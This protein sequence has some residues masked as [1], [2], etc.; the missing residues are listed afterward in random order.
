[1]AGAWNG[2]TTDGG[3]ASGHPNP[4]ADGGDGDDGSDG[5]EGDGDEDGDA[6]GAGASSAVT[7]N[8]RSVRVMGPRC[9]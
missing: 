6:M 2:R 7:S 5:D 8:V 1:V 4:Q 3:G 9:T